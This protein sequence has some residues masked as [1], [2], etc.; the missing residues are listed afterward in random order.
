VRDDTIT[1]HGTLTGPGEPTEPIGPVGARP[2]DQPPADTPVPEPG[3]WLGAVRTHLG[4]AMVLL[5]AAVGIVRITQY[6]WRQGAALIGA[7]LV[8]AALF[9]A[10][11]PPRRAG[12]LAVRGRPVDVLSY[13]GLGALMVFV[14]V[15]IQGGPFG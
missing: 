4:F 14:A 1:E 5:V 15:T 11:L 9:R 3:G 13:A 7:A 12:L 8:L 10:I 6:H 2:A